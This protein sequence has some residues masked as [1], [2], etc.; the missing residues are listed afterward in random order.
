MQRSSGVRALFD[1]TVLNA[2][3]LTNFIIAGPSLSGLL[4]ALVILALFLPMS[5]RHLKGR[6]DLFE[7]LVLTNIALGVMFIGRPLTDLALGT[8][9]HLGYDI[10]RKF[11]EALLVVLIG[12]LSFQLGYHAPISKHWA[13]RLRRPPRFRPDR[14][15]LAAWLFFILGGVLFAA[16]LVKG[17]GLGLLFVLLRG[18]ST[19]DNGIFL[20]STGYFYNGILM[21]AASAL[22]FFA[23]ATVLKRRKNYIWF[24]MT[25][26]PLFIFYGARGTR[27]LLLPLIVAIPTFW[28]LWNR[29]RPSFGTIMIAMIAGIAAIGW[30]GAIRN[31]E[32]LDRTDVGV[33]LVEALTSPFGQIGD[34]LEGGDDEMFDS[35]AN[36]LLIV[37]DQFSYRPGS[38]LT[39]IVVRAI[40]R[41]IWPG[42]PLE[43]SNA[44]VNALWP[45]H[46]AHT[47][48]SA[49]F[50]IIGLFFLDSGYFG[51][52]FGMFLLGVGVATGWRWY[53]LHRDNLNSVLIYS[54]GLPF[55]VMLMR[56]TL[57]DTLSRMLFMVIP[58]VIVMWVS[59]FRSRQPAPRLRYQQ[60]G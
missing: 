52:A 34:I 20:N 59:R 26:L 43:S 35:I 41:P 28:Y 7:P 18:R 3:L 8:V 32:S 47:R 22:I 15:S 25:A 24:F 48:A 57:A 45:A 38:A 39:D 16:F 5:L 46:Y 49:A 21:W 19:E 51:T 54:M 23:L 4:I 60:G 27:G 40:P 10:T 50:S 9:T 29:R 14:A 36:E 53:L 55:V 30:L 6:L 42:K 12:I 56:G 33:V 11:D 13:R 31:A 37:P 58:L 17:G 2:L 1:F 44:L